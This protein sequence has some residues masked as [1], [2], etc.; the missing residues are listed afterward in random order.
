MA[1]QSILVVEDDATILR[2]LSDLLQSEG[3]S[4]TTAR[5]GNE[6]LAAY[7]KK[8][9]DLI[10]LDLMMPEKSGYDV[11]REIRKQDEAT[12]ILMLTAKG[13]EMDKVIGLEL[14]ADDYIV[15][16]F[17]IKELMARVRAHL[18]R[19]GQAGKQGKPAKKNDKPFSFGEITV[20]PKTFTCLK[21]RK[22][23][24]LSAREIFL[25]QYMYEHTSE[26]LDRNVLLDE[27]WGIQYG[28]TTRTLDQHIAKL[29]QKIEDDPAKP[30]HILTVHTVG[31]KFEK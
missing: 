30:K 18:R 20:N 2:G 7:N 9:P 22:E 12:P 25:L 11:C 28:G 17:G 23:Q 5:N 8:R 19:V 13:E 26:I 16:P 31:Y 14:G 10:V 6:G 29:R 1:H 27:V 21:G 24:K 15:K 4:V 3:F